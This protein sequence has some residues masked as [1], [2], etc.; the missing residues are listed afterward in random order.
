VHLNTG[1]HSF[2]SRMDAHRGLQ[3]GQ[4]A[5]LTVLLHKAHVY[6]PE[7]EKLIV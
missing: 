1:K 4:P 6:D 7:T 3:R 2:V 5:E